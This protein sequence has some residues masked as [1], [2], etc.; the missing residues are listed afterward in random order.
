MAG[1]SENKIIRNEKKHTEKLC[2]QIT[3]FSKKLN[4]FSNEN[5]MLVGDSKVRHIYNE[6]ADINY[7]RMLWRSGAELNNTQLVP[8]VDRY[9]RRY[10]N[11]TII[12]WFGTCELTHFT[13][14]TRKYIDI[15]PNFDNIVFTL[16][17]RYVAYKQRLIQFRPTTRV[18]FLDVPFYS[19]INWNKQKGHPNPNSFLENQERLECAIIELNA[20]TK[21]INLPLLP[22]HVIQDMYLFIKRKANQSQTR[23]INYSLLTDGIHPGKEIS[24]LWQ[25]RIKLFCKY[26]Y[27]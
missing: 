17:T 15:V 8:Q 2:K 11:P 25:L 23:K 6:M 4:E 1:L 12:V 21:Q 19:I 5:V 27:Q 7:V 18:V 22:P 20:A 13:G 10:N 9:V 14:N 16:M 3:H 24:H 26:I